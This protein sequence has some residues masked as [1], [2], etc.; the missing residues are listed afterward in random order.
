FWS[1]SCACSLSSLWDEGMLCNKV[2]QSATEQTVRLDSEATLLCTYETEH[3][4]SHLYWYRMRP[5][6]PF[7]FVLYRDN[8][9]SKDADFTQ[10]RFSVKHS[11]TQRTFHLVISSVR[12][13]DSATYYCACGH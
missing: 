13:G 7:Q 5:D 10:G 1:F 12:A 11:Q 3:S 8:T 9:R 2:I 4:N 6:H